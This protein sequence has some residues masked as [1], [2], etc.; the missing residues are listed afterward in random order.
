METLEA[1][2]ESS[3]TFIMELFTRTANGWKHYNEAKMWVLTD[4]PISVENFAY[5]R[6]E[7]FL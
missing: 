1:Y 7:W 5:V 6:N 2:V 3:Q 4:I